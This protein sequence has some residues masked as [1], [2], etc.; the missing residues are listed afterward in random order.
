MIN[1]PE[2]L[3]VALRHLGISKSKVRLITKFWKEFPCN[4][5]QLKLPFKKGLFKAHINGV[6]A[7]FDDMFQYSKMSSWSIT[8]Q[9]LP[10]TAKVQIHAV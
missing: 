7:L 2:H 1:I 5:F 4:I 10:N 6:F 3:A 9:H 8:C